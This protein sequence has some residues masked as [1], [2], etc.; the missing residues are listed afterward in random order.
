MKFKLGLR[1][2]PSYREGDI[3]FTMDAGLAEDA[4]ENRSFKLKVPVRLVKGT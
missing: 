4:F 3:T 1:A 2:H